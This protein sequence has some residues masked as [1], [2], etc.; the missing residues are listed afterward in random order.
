MAVRP[1]PIA[2]VELPLRQ[3][4]GAEVQTVQGGRRPGLES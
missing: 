4:D 2:R 3:Q 1:D